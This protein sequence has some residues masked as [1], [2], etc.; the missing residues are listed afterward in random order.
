LALQH[1]NP[2]PWRSISLDRVRYCVFFFFLF[3]SLCA[4][5]LLSLSPCSRFK[6]T[7]AINTACDREKH[8][9]DAKWQSEACKA[10][11][12]LT[13]TQSTSPIPYLF[14]RHRMLCSGRRGNSVAIAD[15]AILTSLPPSSTRLFVPVAALEPSDPHDPQKLPVFPDCLDLRPTTRPTAFH[16]FISAASVL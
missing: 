6:Q 9:D 3:C 8:T 4:L 15:E 7:A 14:L 16:G 11:P 1:P 5:L 13:G 2:T 10:G 12:G